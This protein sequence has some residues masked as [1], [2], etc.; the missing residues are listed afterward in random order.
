M[1]G[2]NHRIDKHPQDASFLETVTN[3]EDKKN[4][5]SGNYGQVNL[6]NYLYLDVL[7]D[8]K[9]YTSKTGDKAAKLLEQQR[10]VEADP[11]ADYLDDILAEM[12]MLPP[13]IPVS[14]GINP[15]RIKDRTPFPINTTLQAINAPV[16]ASYEHLL[17]Y[18]IY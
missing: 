10:A 18:D 12:A 1:M 17:L 13:V 9:V 15:S 7:L 5:E 8:G 6:A 14:V 11:D 3:E 2:S 16:R 4:L